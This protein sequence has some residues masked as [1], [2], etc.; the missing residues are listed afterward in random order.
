MMKGESQYQTA[1]QSDDYD[2]DLLYDSIDSFKRAINQSF[3]V[4]A[5]TEAKSSAQ[6]G[7]I[8]HRAF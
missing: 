1:T 6:L 8:F 2:M 5:E 3:E 4:D 7:K